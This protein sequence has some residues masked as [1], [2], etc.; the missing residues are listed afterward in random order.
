LKARPEKAGLSFALVKR[1]IIMIS[2]LKNNS[3]E[4]NHKHEYRIPTLLIALEYF[5]EIRVFKM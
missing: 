4:F 2:L 1:L 3:L 5:A